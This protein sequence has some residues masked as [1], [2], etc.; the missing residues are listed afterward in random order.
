MFP[1][2]LVDAS[3]AII[4]FKQNAERFGIDPERVFT[5][6]FSAGGHLSGSCAIMYSAPEVRA[7][8]GISANEN[9][10]CGSVLAYPVVT[11][12]TEIT[13]Q[14]SFENLLGKKFSKITDS[15]K[16]RF[17]LETSVNRESAPMFLWHTVEDKLVPIN[18]TLLLA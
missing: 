7:A 16:K 14:Y 3:R 6:G 11:V 13:H 12:N 4:Y 1:K 10:P 5:V 17:S 2:Q 8:L 15:E 9:K 18:G